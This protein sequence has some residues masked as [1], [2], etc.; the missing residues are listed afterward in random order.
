MPRIRLKEKSPEFDDD[1]QDRPK[2]RPHVRLCD[3]P[4]CTDEGAH[5]AP[6]DRDLKEYYHFCLEHVQDYNKAWNY[7]EG[8]SDDQIQD[9]ILSSLYGERPTRRYDIDG[10]LQ[11]ALQEKIRAF[12]GDSPEKPRAARRAAPDT[13]PP[14][15]EA[16]A[17]SHMGLSVPVTI[18]EIRLR[19]RELV[20]LHHPDRTGGDKT[21]EEV[22][23]IVNMAY[24]IL[25]QAYKKTVA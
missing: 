17:L 14:S 25:C 2:A 13:L 10:R 16:Q 20:R 5:R 6:K 22:L 24:T 7:F 8:L 21:S 11:E 19:Y 9:H 1:S 3:A 18:E 23:K 15:P 4:G 12:F